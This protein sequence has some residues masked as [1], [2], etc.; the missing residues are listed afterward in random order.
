M[1]IGDGVELCSGFQERGGKLT[2]ESD[3]IDSVE[4][5]INL[6]T[7]DETA[8]LFYLS[9]RVPLA[10]SELT[11]EC[12][13]SESHVRKTLNRRFQSE[14]KVTQT[15]FITL[16]GAARTPVVSAANEIL[17]DAVTAHKR[18]KKQIE[19]DNYE[20]AIEEYQES[21]RLLSEVKQRLSA[22]TDVPSKLTDRL[23]TV[24]ETHDTLQKE[25]TKDVLTHRKLLA[26][27]REEAGDNA[28]QIG[29]YEAAATAFE[30]AIDAFEEGKEA[31]IRYNEHRLGSSSSRLDPEKIDIRIDGL[32]RKRNNALQNT[33]D[34]SSGG[35]APDTPATGVADSQKPEDPQ[36]TGT[37]HTQGGSGAAAENR[38]T[39]TTTA[40]SSSKTDIIAAIGGQA[41]QLGRMPR[42]R[43]VTGST[44]WSQNDILDV[45]DSWNDALAAAG[46]D[47]R[48]ALID[49]L[50]RAASDIDGR[51]T[52]EEKNQ[53]GE[54]SAGMYY[55]VFDSWEEALAAADLT[56]TES[57]ASAGHSSP[58]TEETPQPGDFASFGEVP[59]NERYS[60]QVAIKLE[61]EREAGSKK[62]ATLQV[63]DVSGTMV[64][65]DFW[66]KHD[67]DIP[68]ETGSWYVVEEVRLKQWGDAMRQNL[69]STRDTSWQRL[70]DMSVDRITQGED[71]SQSKSE[72]PTESGQTAGTET[73]STTEDGVSEESEG[74]LEQ[75]ES[76]FEED[77]F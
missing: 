41:E 15:G 44:A 50:K 4:P 70:N 26:E 72:R 22:V 18:G 52:V 9:G 64:R 8:L 35:S 49:D 20:S 16:T 37:A 27:Q 7:V 46:I 39:A 38:D 54:F 24:R 69:S 47:K 75:I 12:S 76:E 11:S 3:A 68:T 33:A 14:V 74:L 63:S 66:S 57:D 65:F 13:S 73:V 17:S 62:D 71:H 21:E 48:Q 1:R 77:L 31:V 51:V 25:V 61:A 43:E 32:E 55:D 58:S 36:E 10:V 5:P 60:G 29:D 45:F 19:E 67:I 59:S 56:E 2:G 6:R 40:G 30:E 34:N 28:M 23:E 53:H 42:L